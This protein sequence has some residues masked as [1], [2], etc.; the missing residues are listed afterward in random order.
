MISPKLV[1]RPAARRPGTPVV[2][3]AG[4]VAVEDESQDAPRFVDRRARQAPKVR[5]PARSPSWRARGATRRS[6]STSTTRRSAAR[7]SSSRRRTSSGATTSGRHARRRSPH[8]RARAPRTRRPSARRRS[9][10][11]LNTIL[12]HMD[13]LSRVDT[14]R[15]RAV[16]RTSARPACRCGPTSVRRFR[17]SD[18]REDFAALACGRI[19]PRAA[20]RRRTRSRSGR[21]DGTGFAVGRRAA[22]GDRPRRSDC[23][24]RRSTR[25]VRSSG[26]SRRRPRWVEHSP[27]S[28][29]SRRSSRRGSIVD[30]VGRRRSAVRCRRAGRRQGQHRDDDMPTSC[31]SRILEGYVSPYEATAVARLRAA[32][33]DRRRQDRTWTNSRWARPPRTARSVRRRIRSRPIACRADHRAVRRPPLPRGSSRIALGSETGGSVR[34]PAAFCGIVGVK[35]T[36]GR[37]SRYGLVAFASSL[38]HIGVFG[39]TVDDAA[40]GLEVIAGARSARLDE[41]RRAGAERIATR[42]AVA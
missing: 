39:R 8:R 32:G 13:V 36:Y 23:R 16:R 31:G 18:A 22:R 4:A 1:R 40:L 11:E 42:R 12:E 28:G 7:R 19:L 30:G 3:F 38:D 25:V 15:H 10:R 26:R 41:R 21:H 20:A 6:R 5:Q 9:S 27:A 29:R 2:G 34:Q 37:V 14:S 24:R 17:S 33:A 35:P